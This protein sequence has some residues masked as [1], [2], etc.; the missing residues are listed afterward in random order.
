MS[1]FT[2]ETILKPVCAQRISHFIAIRI[3]LEDKAKRIFDIAQFAR[4]LSGIVFTDP[5][6][7]FATVFYNRCHQPFNIRVLN[8]KVCAASKHESPNDLIQ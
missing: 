6:S 5:N 2:S 3:D 8:A 4:L 1:A 7:L